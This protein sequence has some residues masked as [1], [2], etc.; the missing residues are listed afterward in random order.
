MLPGGVEGV[1]HL[2]NLVA[3]ESQEIQPGK[4]IPEGKYP[5]PGSD[6]A[7]LMVLDHQAKCY[8]LFTKASMH[9]RRALWLEEALAKKGNVVP[10]AKGTI[11]AKIAARMGEEILQYMLFCNEAELLGD[12]AETSEEFLKAFQRNAKRVGDRNRS[13]KDLRLYGHLF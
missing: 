6:V 9:Y 2:G 3:G 11:S 7:A 12:G 5:Y 13:L 1:G 10:G 4:L 8:T